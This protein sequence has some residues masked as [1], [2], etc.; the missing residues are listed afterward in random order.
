MRY[1]IRSDWESSEGVGSEDGF[2]LGGGEVSFLVFFGGMLLVWHTVRRCL[3][4][5]VI[6]LILCCGLSEVREIE[7][8]VDR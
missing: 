1:D 8:V 5:F 3:H 2:G 4:L 7:T 6:Q